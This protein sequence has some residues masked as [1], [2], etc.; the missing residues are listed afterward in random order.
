MTNG[1]PQVSVL[2]PM[3]NAE[4]FVGEALRSLLYGQDVDLEV[5]VVDDG[6]TDGSRDVIARLNDAR[7][8]V[9]DGPQTGVAG[10]FNAGLAEVRAPIVV[11]CD[12]D[13]R[14]E[15]GRLAW[16][17]A[18][19]NSHSDFGAIC[20]TFATMTGAGHLLTHMNTGECEEEIT[21]EFLAGKTR[22][23]MCT[24]AIRT[25]VLRSING[26]RPY[27]V[28][29]SDIDLQLRV[30]HACRVWYA[31]RNCYWYRLHDDS[32][33]HTKRAAERIFF[34]ETA[35]VFSRQRAETGADDLDRGCAAPPPASNGSLP[36]S[37]V[38][39]MQDILRGQS[40]REHHQGRK[41][42]AVW[43]GMRACMM[44]PTKASIWKS[45]AAL[46]CKT[47]RC[48]KGGAQD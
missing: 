47:P 27:F 5:V 40:W 38:E 22:T 37:V 2:M 34:D 14:Y 39:Q 18:W 29:S 26:C 10:A 23:H 19:L 31:P 11:R 28:T 46:I 35:R 7:V 4:Q 30:G 25:D 43:I 12:A 36:L 24:F 21:A 32:I 45:L 1:T 17:T 16:Q 48:R 15:P 20:G 41:A 8:R 13:D 44:R 3:R 33:T 42:R 9:V 6:S